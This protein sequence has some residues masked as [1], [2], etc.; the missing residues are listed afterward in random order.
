MSRQQR[1]VFMMLLTAVVMLVPSVVVGLLAKSV[2]WGLLTCLLIGMLSVTGCVLTLAALK[3]WPMAR[4]VFK[5][6]FG[7]RRLAHLLL[8]LRAPRTGIRKLELPALVDTTVSTE[9]GPSPH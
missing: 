1:I 5:F 2:I 6:I 8:L 3:D 7:K 4:Q 9:P